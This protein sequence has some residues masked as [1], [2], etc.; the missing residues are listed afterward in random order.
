MIAVDTSALMAI[1]LN[2][3]AAEDCERSATTGK[4]PELRIAEFRRLF[5]L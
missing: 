1:L 3:A 4:G 5:R 2:E